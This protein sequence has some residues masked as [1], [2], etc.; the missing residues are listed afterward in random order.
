MKQY[1]VIGIGDN[2][3]DKYVHQGMMYPGG[4]A[5]NFCAYARM[6]EMQSSYIGKFG[7]DQVAEYI[8]QVM[9]KLEI[10]HSHCRIFEG[11]NGYARVTLENGDRIFLGSNKGGIAK[12]KAWDFTEEDLNYIE[13]FSVIHTSLNSYIE[14]DLKT[15]KKSNVPISFD[16]SVRWNDEYLEQVCRHADISFLSCSHLS[17]SEREREMR[18][19]QTFGSQMVIGTVGENG[20]YALYKDQWIY[21]QAELT[22]TVDTMGAGDS[23]L[24]AFLIGMIRSSEDGNMFSGSDEEML[25]RIKASMEQGAAFAA[26]ICRINGAFGYGTAIL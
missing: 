17:D 18:K 3:V 7:N 6:C 13:Q 12:E 14:G 19:A 16:F 5:L 21:Q 26:K 2:V 23:Y 11:E 20:S 10:E 25:R 15:L 22:E 1:K 9:E 24:T 4:N 8:K